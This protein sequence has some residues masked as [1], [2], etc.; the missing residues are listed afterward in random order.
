MQLSQNELCTSFMS[1]YSRGVGLCILTKKPSQKNS[2]N[3]SRQQGAQQRDE[4]FFLRQTSNKLTADNMFMGA[5]RASA[6]SLRY[7]RS[8]IFSFW[9]EL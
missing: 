3:A 4:S 8:V 5:H 9:R 7:V 6:S 2:L 1:L